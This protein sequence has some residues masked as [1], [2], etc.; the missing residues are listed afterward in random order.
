MSKEYLKLNG[1]DVGFQNHPAEDYGFIKGVLD[2]CVEVRCGKLRI[3]L[4]TP[5]LHLDKSLHNGLLLKDCN[6]PF[7][8]FV[9][10][11]DLDIPMG[12]YGSRVKFPLEKYTPG[13]QIYE[14]PQKE[15]R[16]YGEIEVQEGEL[17]I[18]GEIRPY[19]DQNGDREYSNAVPVEIYKRF[20]AKPL[21]PERVLYTLKQARGKDP[22]EVYELGIKGHQF[23]EFPAE[24]L[25]YKNLERLVFYIGNKCEFTQLPDAF[26]DLHNLHT[27][28]FHDSVGLSRFSEAFTQLDKLEQLSIHSRALTTIPVSLCE[29]SNLRKLDLSDC[30]LKTLPAGIGDMPNL[31]YLN[32][33]G[34]DF[35]ELPDSLN[36]IPYLEV[37]HNHK[38]LFMDA[39]YQSANPNPID[40]SLYDLSDYPEALKTLED[41]LNK[42]PELDPI[43]AALVKYSVMGTELVPCKQ[44][45]IPLGASKVGGMPDLPPHLQYPTQENG[46]YSFHA[47]INCAEAAPYQNYLPRQ[48]M[49]YFFVSDEESVQTAK[50][51]YSES[52]ENLS[53]YALD[54]DSFFYDESIPDAGYEAQAVAFKNHLSIPIFSHIT[55]RI[56]LERFPECAELWKKPEDP[57]EFEAY[58]ERMDDINYSEFDLKSTSHHAININVFTQNESPQEQASARYGGDAHEWMVLLCME[59]EGSFNFWDAGTLT[60]CIHKKDLAINDFSTIYASIESS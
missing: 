56:A 5:S 27:L 8:R 18:R 10:R 13:F 60:Y 16:F 40:Q 45:E 46:L 15:V 2:N 49:L 21:L 53:P 47:Q 36:N 6:T 28:H 37:D 23:K 52:T 59:S 7:I 31:Q 58:D 4:I 50:V 42:H 11:D 43:K 29:L 39:G 57:D 20:E 35:A 14:F 12:Q 17:W 1:I 34:N 24:V 33:Q 48:G 41:A 54:D 22:M 32:I 38:K 26:F 19:N 3:N 25:D 30:Q 51:L 9:L 44:N 55:Q